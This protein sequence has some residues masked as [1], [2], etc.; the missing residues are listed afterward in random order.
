M[1]FTHVLAVAPVREIEP[2]VAWYERLLGRA[3]N[4]TPMP[5]LADWH[6][7]PWVQVC[8]SPDHAGSAL[9][10]GLS[11]LGALCLAAVVGL[12][13]GLGEDTGRPATGGES[14]PPTRPGTSPNR[15]AER[16]PAVVEPS[17][18]R[19]PVEDVKITSCAVDPATGRPSAA[20]TITNSGDRT[21]TFLIGV[22]F[23]APDGSRL[24]EGAA[25]SNDLA[26]GQRA[27][28][29]AADLVQLK[30]E[31]RCDVLK[32]TVLPGS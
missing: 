4:T 8:E 11:M 3:P 27:N 19:G 13:I 10:V 25:V 21:R 20:L 29:T 32:V 9:V 5:G 23:L 14:A 6:V 15:T 16:T 24:A 12:L 31:I 18:D 26:P 7:S 2:A 28:V 22:E 1:A 30:D 17:S